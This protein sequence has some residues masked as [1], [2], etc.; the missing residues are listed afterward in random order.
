MSNLRTRPRREM[1]PV[2]SINANMFPLAR[3]GINYY[4]D[5]I[6]QNWDPRPA[7]YGADMT[8]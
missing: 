4:A 8:P 2:H 3:L 1:A 5:A 7:K 6:M